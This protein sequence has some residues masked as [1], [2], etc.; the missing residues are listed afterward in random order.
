MYPWTMNCRS[1]MFMNELGHVCLTSLDH[2]LCSVDWYL[3][4]AQQSFWDFFRSVLC[5]LQ[6][7][8]IR[9][10][11]P[12]VD[13]RIHALLFEAKF[14]SL[15]RFF[16]TNFSLSLLSLQA[17]FLKLSLTSLLKYSVTWL[18]ACLYTCL[19]YLLHWCW[20]SFLMCVKFIKV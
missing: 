4:F 17:G 18:Y 5:W 9:S 20:I 11:S 10:R 7:S 3:K 12:Y 15:Q 13:S 14:L 19:N 1:A 2:S 8:A 6:L 16:N